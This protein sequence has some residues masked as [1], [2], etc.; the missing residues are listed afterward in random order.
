MLKPHI[1]LGLL[2]VR[3]ETVSSFDWS[4]TVC[5]SILSDS[6]ENGLIVTFWGINGCFYTECGAFILP[7]LSIHYFFFNSNVQSC[8]IDF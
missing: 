2:S 6:W 8:H 1:N 7:W 4:T 5:V 3:Y